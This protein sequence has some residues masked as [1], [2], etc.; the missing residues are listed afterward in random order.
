MEGGKL[1]RG[2]FWVID[3]ALLAYPFA[4]GVYAGGTARSGVTYNHR[5]LW[6]QLHG[7]R[8]KPYNYYPRGR[9]DA[10]NKGQPVIYM[11]PHVPPALLPEIQAVFAITTEPLLRYDNIRHYRCHLDD[12]WGVKGKGV[13]SY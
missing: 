11:S 2:V 5:K 12:G 6:E 3:G 8:G 7:F 4:E 1:Y 9:V 13:L 10:D